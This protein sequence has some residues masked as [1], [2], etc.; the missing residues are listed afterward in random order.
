MHPW[1]SG[2]LSE[3]KCYKMRQCGFVTNNPCCLF[4]SG[5]SS[6]AKAAA[7]SPSSEGGSVTATP[8]VKSL[9]SAVMTMR[10]SVKKV[11]TMAPASAAQDSQHGTCLGFSDVLI[12]LTYKL[13]PNSL[14]S[15]RQRKTPSTRSLAMTSSSLARGMWAKWTGFHL[16]RCVFHT[17]SCPHLKELPAQNQLS[18]ELFVL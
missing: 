17:I 3:E 13:L 15:Q 11:R 8:S 18:L 16:R 7:S 4:C 2:Q 10:V 12:L 9:A 1:G 14:I 6:P 5:Q